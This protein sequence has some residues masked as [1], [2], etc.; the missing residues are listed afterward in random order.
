MAYANLAYC[1]QMLNDYKKAIKHYKKAIDLNPE[2]IDAISQLAG[3]YNKA[4]ELDMAVNLNKRIMKIDSN[5]YVPYIN[6]GNYYF[7]K[8]DTVT[9]VSYWEEAVV[10]YPYN[11]KLCIILSSYFQ[12]K[13]DLEKANYYYR[14]SNESGK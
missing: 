4:G 11:R 12:K 2:F 3:L 8:A 14:K 1:Y 10:K 5:S 6:I 9:A 7:M 13:G